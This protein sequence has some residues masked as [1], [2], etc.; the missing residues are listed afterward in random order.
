MAVQGPALVSASRP[1]LAGRAGKE[2]AEYTRRPRPRKVRPARW[3]APLRFAIEIHPRMRAA[4]GACRGPRRSGVVPMIYPEWSP[5]NLAFYGLLTAMA[6]ASAPMELWGPLQLRYSK[7]RAATGVPSRDGM[8]FIY[9][10]PLVVLT[11][12]SLPYLHDP[13]LV[14]ALVFDAVFLHFVKRCFESLFLHKY[15]GP[16]DGTTVLI[17]AGL[18]SLLA[19]MVG[20]LNRQPLPDMDYIAWAGAVL[21]LVG[22]TGNFLHHKRLAD[23]RRDGKAYILPHGLLFD[24]AICP[25][26]LFELLSWLGV[27]LVSRHLGLALL[28]CFMVGYLSMRSLKTLRW[29]RERFPKFPSHVRA[30]VPFVF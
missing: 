26:Y 10:V 1:G 8:L 7:F 23:L 18:Y 24:Y 6:L 22:E 5:F 28:F 13:S 11:L 3:N 16:M 14:Q 2:A 21:W 12:F 30:L 27:V 4:S 19:A 15:S 25:H 20:Y 29:Y 17:V 9:T